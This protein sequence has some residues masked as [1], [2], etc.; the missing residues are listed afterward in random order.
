MHF[1]ALF[2]HFLCYFHRDNIYKLESETHAG[3]RLQAMFAEK[4]QT[5][6]SIS[7]IK[8]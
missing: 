5:F 6:S 3:Q 8:F 4:N 1:M 7:P 2:N